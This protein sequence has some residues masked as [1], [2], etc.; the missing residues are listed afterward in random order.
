[1]A[2]RAYG[3]LPAQ[4]GHLAEFVH[5]FAHLFELFDKQVYF[6]DFTPAAFGDA[7]LAAHIEQVRI[8][9]LGRGHG[10]NVYPLRTCRA[11]CPLERNFVQ[12]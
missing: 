8:G 12:I 2:T 3:C 9:A 11:T 6:T 7:L 5:H 4:S 1:M 10:K